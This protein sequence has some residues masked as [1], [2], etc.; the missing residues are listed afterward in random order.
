MTRRTP[1]PPPPPSSWQPAPFEPGSSR[2]PLDDLTSG[3]STGSAGMPSSARR[4]QGLTMRDSIPI[5]V[6]VFLGLLA[7][8][9]LSALVLGAFGACGLLRLGKELD[10]TQ[11]TLQDQ[12]K[13]LGVDGA[14]QG[15]LDEEGGG[16]AATDVAMLQNA[17]DRFRSDTGRLPS[18]WAEMMA[19]TSTD[20]NYHGPYLTHIPQPP[21]GG[22]YDMDKTT[23]RVYE[24]AP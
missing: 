19:A 8:S 10:Q 17:V 24:A 12:L 9:L 6:G 20:P 22:Y 16:D 4:A 13:A 5:A 11:S 1:P 2:E 15:L 14:T 21:D 23:G 18:T 7:F 3:S